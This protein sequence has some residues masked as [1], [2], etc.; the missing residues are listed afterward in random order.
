MSLRGTE[1]IVVAGTEGDDTPTELRDVAK[2]IAKIAANAKP[3]RLE[4]VEREGR[5]HFSVSQEVDE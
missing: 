2:R 4:I 1:E 3:V 5:G